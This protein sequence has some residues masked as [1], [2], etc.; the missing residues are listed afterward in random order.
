MQ[1]VMRLGTVSCAFDPVLTHTTLAQ[2]VC[3]VG[4]VMQILS[5]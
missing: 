3:S 2:C 5:V 1:L 4:V